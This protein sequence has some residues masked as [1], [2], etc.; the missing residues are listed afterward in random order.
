MKDGCQYHKDGDFTPVSWDQAFDLMAQKWKQT[1]RE[2]ADGHRHVR[3]GQWTVWEGYAAVKLMKAGFRSNNLDPNARHCMA[4]AAVGFMRT[5]GMDEPTLRRIEQAD[6]FV[7]WGSNMAEMHPILWQRMSD[8]KLSA[9]NVT[10]NVLSTYEHRSFELADLPIVFTPQTDIAILNYIANYIIQKGAVNRDFINKHVNFKL[11]RRH[12]LR[13]QARA[14]AAEG[15]EERG[16]RGGSKPM[17]FDEFTRFVSKYDADSTSK[18]TGV[19]KDKL[20][21]L[22]SSMPTPRSR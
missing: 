21:R 16:R 7:L 4:S 3:S 11:E 22:A 9:P 12:R 15:G 5:F 19:P 18:L 8:R 13:P 10:V 1:L 2:K 6:A 14:P 20:E 17:N